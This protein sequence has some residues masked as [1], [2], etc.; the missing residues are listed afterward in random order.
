MSSSCI[1][2]ESYMEAAKTGQEDWLSNTESTRT[3]SETKT[4]K[5]LI[6]KEKGKLSEPWHE[7]VEQSFV[8]DSAV[9]FSAL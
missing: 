1:C 4:D 3:E 9:I 7:G 8:C 6:K 5:N 2:T